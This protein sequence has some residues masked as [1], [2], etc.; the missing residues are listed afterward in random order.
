MFS[1]V[2]ISMSI[3]YKQSKHVIIE[4]Q[5][6]NHRILTVRKYCEAV[7]NMKQIYRN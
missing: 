4:M 7:E 6:S 5:M 3:K 2:S 1:Q